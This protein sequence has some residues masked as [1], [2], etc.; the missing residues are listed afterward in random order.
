MDLLSSVLR[1]VHA[2]AGL[3]GR[4]RAGGDWSLR[5]PPPDEVKF[6]AVVEGD[7]WL[8]AD[9]EPEPIHLR[10]G[11]SFLLVKAQS[12]VLTSNPLLT[13]LPAGTVF[14]SLVDGIAV[15]GSGVGTLVIGG[16]LAL[17]QRSSALLLGQ[18]PP[19][20]LV[21]ADKAAS[22]DLRWALHL[23]VGE[24]GTGEPG[25]SLLADHLAQMIVILILRVFQASGGA[26]IAGWMRGLGDRQVAAA[27]HAIQTE[28]ARSWSVRDLAAAVGMSRTSFAGRFAQL[29]GLGPMGYL[30]E[31]RVQ[32][33]A[34]LLGRETI[35]LAAVAAS[36]GFASEGALTAAFRRR[37]GMTPARYRR[38]LLVG[39]KLA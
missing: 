27:L 13:P 33:A 39:S 5:F 7:C 29:V 14:S 10:A 1:M 2:R 38:T 24:V 15:A 23:L 8:I 12:Y 31:W 36:T 6:N 20:V 22:E 18:L 30:T 19:L 21:R 25:S 32:L 3:S 11:D 28:P 26:P 35:S 34:D 9:S 16:Q 37:F 4:L 17:E